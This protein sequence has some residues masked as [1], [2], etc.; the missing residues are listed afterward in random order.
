M[1]EFFNGFL[2]SFNDA[3][4]Q[5]GVPALSHAMDL[6]DRPARVLLA[7]SRAFDFQADSLPDN[8][9][10][11]GPLLDQPSWSESWH[12]P[13]C[14]D[15]PRVLIAG[16]TGAQ[17]QGELIQKIISAMSQLDIEAVATAGPNLDV[18]TLQ[19]PNN[20]HL[21]RSAPHNTVMREV[22]LVISQGG[23]GTVT[24]ALVNGLPLLVLPMGRDQGDNAARVEAKGAGLRLP[25]TASEQEIASA[26][27][28]LILEP[29]FRLA[30][31]RLGAAIAADIDG[32][33]L[34]REMETVAAM[35]RHDRAPAA[36]LARTA[37]A[38]RGSRRIAV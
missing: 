10:Y 33:A 3:C 12:A 32:A 1:I 23:H 18:D 34:V 4:T 25:P 26:V 36:A 8:L 20:V 9:R 11:V 5:L 35:P 21:L 30:A 14:T 13:W 17:G 31:R 29:R 7:I 16:S 2:P 38:G 22:S 24:R 19:A 37:L 6:F 15:R 27:A 28:S